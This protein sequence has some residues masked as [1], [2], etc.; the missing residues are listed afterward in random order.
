MIAAR[1]ADQLSQENDVEVSVVKG[2]F[3]ELSVYIDKQMAITTNPLW[4][5]L[6]ANLTR[7][8]RDLLSGR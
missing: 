8:T 7:R 2:G 1:V 4:Y 3:L 5:P 6:P